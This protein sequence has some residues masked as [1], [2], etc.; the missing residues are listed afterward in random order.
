MRAD[1]EPIVILGA[2]LAGLSLAVALRRARNPAPLVLIDR[3]TRWDHDRTWCTWLTGPLRFAELA[4]HRWSSWRAAAH[5]GDDQAV[6]HSRRHPYIHLASDAVYEAALGELAD[7]PDV[8]LRTDVQ[9][10]GVESGPA[11]P[12]V[13]TT[14]G[15]FDAARVFDAMGP[16]SPLLRGRPPGT[17]ELAQRFLGWEVETDRPVFTPETATLMDFRAP[18]PDCLVFIYVLPFST[19]RAL[20]EH[21]TIGTGAVAAAARRDALSAELSERHGVREWDVVREE[22]GHIPMS[23]FPF[24]AHRGPGLHAVGAAAGAIR[25]SS[26]YAFSRIQRHV[27]RIVAALATGAELPGSVA[28]SRYRVLDRIFLRALTDGAH[29]EELFLRLMA[30]VSGDV[31]ARFMTDRSSAADEAR[32]LAVLPPLTM[33]AAA[34][35]LA[36]SPARMREALRTI[37]PWG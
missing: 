33:T 9:V 1:D 18:A 31:F 28:P 35:R 29:G 6:Q 32:V 17:T 2:G 13:T 19:T 25:P 8:E 36:A 34:L 26:G 12:R 4:S 5:V 27:D 37:R 22:K 30:G 14:N 7:A 10:L 16:G 21:T 20:V 3:R 15:T 23:T 11:S 24:P